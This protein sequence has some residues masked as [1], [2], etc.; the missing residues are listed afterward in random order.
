MIIIGIKN[1]HDSGVTVI[2]DGRIIFAVNEERLNRIKSFGGFPVLSL[3]AALDVIK[4]QTVDA[5]AL[6]GITRFG[7]PADF[8]NPDSIR[9]FRGMLSSVGIDRLLVG[10]NS[11]VALLFS[12]LKHLMANKITRELNSISLS[13]T[14]VISVDHHT[15]HAAGAFY[16]SG[17][18]DCLVLTMDGS[19][20]G[21][22]SK[23]FLPKGR[24]LKQVH[25]I[26]MFHSVAAYYAYATKLLGFKVNRHEGKLVGLAAYTE[27]NEDCLDIFRK[28]LAYDR[29]K[30]QFVNHGKWG[31]EETRALKQQLEPFSREEIANAIQTH[32][33]ELVV[34]YVSD[35]YQK[36]KK[37]KIALSGGLFANVKLNQR[38]AEIN[39]IEEIY[40]FPNMG[41]GGNHTGAAYWACENVFNE[42]TRPIEHLYLGHSY[43]D[44]EVESVL[45]KEKLDYIRVPDPEKEIAALLHKGKII[46]RFNGGMEYGPRALGNRSVIYHAEDP[47]VNDW[48]NRQLK[49]TEFMPFAPV[50]LEQDAPAMMKDYGAINC[51]AMKY[52][53]ITGD[54]TEAFARVGSAAVHVDQTARPQVVGESDNP[55]LFRVL[56]EYKKLT[57]TGVLINTSFNMHEE[58]IVCS[59]EDAVRAYQAAGLDVLAIGSYIVRQDR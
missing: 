56:T 18:E 10:S 17:W 24:Q 29:A 22:S 54:V 51:R 35:L 39:G 42:R 4:G 31:W 32:T 45:K 40:V 46:A 58:P 19:G 13:R 44:T 36:F 26:P 59:P 33:E 41:D 43:S 48:L 30:M 37:S 9:R 5:I 52:M 53:T 8:D 57:G 47:S 49:R 11:R 28:R 55:S 2:K 20:D 15:S 16:G 27:T 1:T 38:I 14:K 6:D 21:Y 7:A 50:I 34:Q 25:T 12:I 23:A 3:K